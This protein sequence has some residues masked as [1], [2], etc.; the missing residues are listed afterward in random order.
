MNHAVLETLGIESPEQIE[1][2]ALDE[3]LDPAESERLEVQALRDPL[4]GLLNRRSLEEEFGDE[5][6]RAHRRGS[7]LSVLML[8]IDHF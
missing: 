7:P 2:R 5:V 3:F 6:E 1:G 4:T 8:D